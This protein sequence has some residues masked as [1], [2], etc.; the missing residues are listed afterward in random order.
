MTLDDG[1]ECSAGVHATEL[2]HL[3]HRVFFATF[4]RV[5]FWLK[6]GGRMHDAVQYL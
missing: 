5:Y 3:H 1:G 6:K 2:V 4:A